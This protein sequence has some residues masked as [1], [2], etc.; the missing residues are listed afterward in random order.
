MSVSFLDL[1]AEQPNPPKV[2]DPAR[3]A[4]RLDAKGRAFVRDPKTITGIGIH[5]TACVFGP[6]ADREKAHRRALGVHAH[7]TAFRD[8][9]AVL[10]WPLLWRVNHGNGL[11]AASLGLECEGHYPGVPD[12]PTTPRRED[13]AS[14]GGAPTVLDDLSLETFC[15]GLKALVD[16]GRAIGCPIE[17]VWAHRQSSDTRR[18]DPG[19][20][21][22]QKVVLDYGVKVLGLKTESWK[23][24]AGQG[25]PIPKQWDPSSPEKY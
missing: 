12:D 6:K 1:S 16:G 20:E 24:F 10:G 21:I 4:L 3:P 18:A 25:K 23:T 22:W 5:Q 11:N 19:W 2:L 7:M 13:Q 9:V 17:F 14:I 15:F 8:G